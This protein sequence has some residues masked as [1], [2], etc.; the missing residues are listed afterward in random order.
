MA[1]GLTKDICPALGLG[2][3]IGRPVRLIHASE[4]AGRIYDRR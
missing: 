2:V 3:T 4:A 1:I